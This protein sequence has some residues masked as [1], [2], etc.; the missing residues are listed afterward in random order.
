M[1]FLS[2]TKGVRAD[3]TIRP[4]DLLARGGENLGKRGDYFVAQRHLQREDVKEAVL[5]KFDDGMK[6]C[7]AKAQSRE[8]MRVRSHSPI[9]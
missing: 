2:A 6:G 3:A 8:G 4:H 9:R 1:F 7:H 5:P